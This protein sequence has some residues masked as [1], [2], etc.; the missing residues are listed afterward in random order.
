MPTIFPRN[1]PKIK[2][3]LF[4]LAVLLM[5]ACSDS[6]SPQAMYAN[7]LYRLGNV[8]GIDAPDAPPPPPLPTYPRQRDLV[9]QTDDVRVGLITYLDMAD[10]DLLQEVSERN[11]SLGRV[12]AITARLLYEIHFYQ[13]ISLCEDKLRKMPD[14]DVAFKNQIA[15]IRRIK[16]VNLPKV[17]WNATFAS[18]EFAKL[19]NSAA[20]PLRRNETASMTDI[21]S[22]LA[23]LARMG[24]ALKTSPLSVEADAFERHYFRLQAGK[25]T[26]KLLQGLSLSQFHLAQASALLKQTASAKRLCPQGKKTPKGEY[27]F[28][29]FVKYYAGEVQ[30]Y[31]SRL[32]QT[33]GPLL[34]ALQSL[35]RAQTAEPPNAFLHYYAAVLDP[36][37]A[38]GLW[39]A[40]NRA[41][42]EHTRAWQTVLQQCNLMPNAPI[43]RY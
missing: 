15:E 28:N 3:S 22:S 37:A 16:G 40:F 43:E 4:L 25:R 29:V 17:F 21:E 30:P 12:Q 27:L 33:T 41:L 31:L 38:Q 24:A 14:A 10:C 36:D 5:N 19:L 20:P 26:G 32:H 23:F 8:T 6:G 42:N 39:Q 34:T 11:S 35:R 9:L 13:K 2:F 1:R 7:Y 18:P